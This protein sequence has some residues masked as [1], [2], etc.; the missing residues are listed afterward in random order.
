LYDFD[1]LEK[2]AWSAVVQ[3]RALFDPYRG[4]AVALG[5]ALATFG[6]GARGEGAPLEWNEGWRRFDVWD[7]AAT[8][9]FA[10]GSIALALSPFREDGHVGGVLFDEPVREA[11]VAASYRGRHHARIVGDIGYRAAILYPYLVDVLL[12]AAI[13]HDSGDVAI[14]MLLI[15]LQAHSISAFLSLASEHGIG[16]AR[17]SHESCERDPDYERFCG[18]DDRFASFV[19]GHTATA[20]ASAGL[21]CAHHEKL[22]LYGGGIADT[23]ACL[24]AIGGAATVGIAR[25]V[26]DRHWA[27]DVLA[28]SAVGAFA[29]YVVPTWLHY[30]FGDTRTRPPAGAGMGFPLIGDRALG[31]GFAGVF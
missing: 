14:Q 7:A 17:P 12:G 13:A 1:N 8:V 20:V 24:G 11:L 21:V 6:R 16:R 10:S 4:R 22:P 26:N 25:I 3:K 15:D 30:G 9:A 27:T 23:L 28:G 2:E 19:S 18:S 31:L 29:G 5:V